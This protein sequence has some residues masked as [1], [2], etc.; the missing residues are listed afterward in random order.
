MA[1]DL[2]EY[3]IASQREPCFICRI[4]DGTHPVPHEVIYRDDSVIAFLNRFPTLY[5]YCLV[6]PIE[7]HVDVVGDFDEGDYLRLQSIVRRVAQA[8][9]AVVPTERMYVLSLGSKQGNDHVHWHVAPLPPGVPYEDQQLK[10]LMVETNGYIQ[11]DADQ[12]TEL[13]D[14]LRRA[15]FEQG[16]PSVTDR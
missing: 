7:H 2:T 6:A 14:A 9:G 15:L 11:L 5:G 1:L 8:V 16:S 12:Q 3:S 4:I 13:A 10:A